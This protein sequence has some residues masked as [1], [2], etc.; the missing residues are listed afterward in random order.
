MLAKSSGSEVGENQWKG[1]R[2]GKGISNHYFSQLSFSFVRFALSTN[3][4]D[5]G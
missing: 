3:P 5:W 4:E 2:I 1:C